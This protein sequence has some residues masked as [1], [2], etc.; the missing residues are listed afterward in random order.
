MD[1]TVWTSLPNRQ[2]NRQLRKK[3]EV[4]T[5]Q[6]ETRQSVE[7]D[8]VENDFTAEHCRTGSLGKKSSVAGEKKAQLLAF[9]TIR[10]APSLTF[11]AEQAAEQA[12]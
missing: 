9:E 12:A 5:R 1:F 10:D 4:E 2:P 3:S 11:T 6:S 7:N 8:F